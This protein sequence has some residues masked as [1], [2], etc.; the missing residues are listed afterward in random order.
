MLQNRFWNLSLQHSRPD[1]L[2]AFSTRS[3][4]SYWSNT[5]AEPKRAK[6][7]ASFMVD[8]RGLKSRECAQ[9]LQAYVSMSRVAVGCYVKL[10]MPFRCSDGQVESWR[11][12]SFRF[13]LICFAGEL[14]AYV[15]SKDFV[16]RMDRLQSSSF[17]QTSWQQ[18]FPL[19]SRSVMPPLLQRDIRV[20]ILSGVGSLNSIDSILGGRSLQLVTINHALAVILHE[21]SGSRLFA[22]I[23][24]QH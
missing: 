18:T 2:I 3:I 16:R 6:K 1:I 10:T 23:L 17:S 21:I 5:Y 9:P 12:R 24:Y 15:T 8:F 4:P 14:V 7:V 13:R 19:Q 20:G 11:V 22:N